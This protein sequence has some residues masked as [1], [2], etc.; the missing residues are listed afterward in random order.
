M[1][2]A[3]QGLGL[4]EVTSDLVAHPAETIVTSCS[5]LN[6]RRRI[7]GPRICRRLS[8]QQCGVADT[9]GLNKLFGRLV[10]LPMR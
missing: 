2:F 9:V 7:Q 10:F 8:D 4:L 3:V 5:S 1:M 6:V